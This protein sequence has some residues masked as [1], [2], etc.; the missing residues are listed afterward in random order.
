MIAG[1]GLS[2]VEDVVWGPAAPP[3]GLSGAPRS[4][5]RGPGPRAPTADTVGSHEARRT[6]PATPLVVDAKIDRP[7]ARA[8]VLD[9]PDLWNALDRAADDTLTVLVAPAGYGK[10]TTLATWAARRG[11]VA[12][13]TLDSPDGAP[14]RLLAHVLRTLQRTGH[15][16]GDAWPALVAGA[17]PA[18]VVV[19]LLSNALGAASRPPVLVVDDCHVI[20]GTPSA[21]VVRSL[22]DA[23]PNRLRLVL[24][25]RRAL[26]WPLARRRANGD[27][28][29]LGPDELRLTT[30]EIRALVD[31]RLAVGLSETETTGLADATE[32]WP[33][34]V[35]LTLLR[36]AAGSR[37]LVRDGGTPFDIAEYLVQEV[38]DE[39]DDVMRTFLRRTSI[40]SV[41]DADLCRA[42][43][44]DPAAGELLARARRSNLLLARTDA[45]GTTARYHRLLADVLRAE[46]R[47]SEPE[48][49]GDL[50]RRAGAW[51]AEARRYEDAIEHAIHAGDATW[52]VE[53]LSEI[54]LDLVFDRRY[55]TITSI[56]DRLPGPVAEHD[57]FVAALRM[58]VVALRD[59]LGAAE[60]RAIRDLAAREATP[61]ARRVLRRLRSSFVCGDVRTALDCVD[62]RWDATEPDPRM[63]FAAATQRAMLWW[64]TD[65]P[66]LEAALK[67]VPPAGTDQTL[68]VWHHAMLAFAAA[69]TADQARAVEHGRAAVAEAECDV[70]GTSISFA[71]AYQACGAA[72]LRYGALDHAERMLDRASAATGQV[73]DG[74]EHL[75][76]LMLR[77]RL[78]LARGHRDSARQLAAAAR[79]IADDCV[80]LG[81]L[82]RHLDDTEE[83][84]DRPSSNATLGSPLSPAELRV[85]RM[86]PGGLPLSRIASELFLSTNTVRTHA[87]MIYRRLGANSRADAI[88]AARTRGLLPGIAD[89]PL[90]RETGDG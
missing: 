8:E 65:D 81:G 84:I 13:V 63:R 88:A 62:E 56:L 3:H 16:T 1:N 31:E 25:S 86:L 80:D 60:R 48:A 52:A 27:V 20:E 55:D 45:D 44:D 51:L 69:G 5:R 71:L 79:A 14:A 77:A 57:T 6:A 26:P 74:V 43:L 38:L 58:A 18:S 75:L 23:A 29:E 39:L 17:D 73:P 61:E 59:G 53:L 41:L 82:T 15:E 67:T 40:L 68:R 22:A 70:T 72:Y 11:D 78:E 47:R 32:G 49:V 24:A 54:W 9:R 21:A 4:R 50:H 37:A 66:R 85:L 76:T 90:L 7:V 28:T 19:P 87:R 33:A 34:A 10:T 64:L 89:D 46:L 12:W 35:A 42:V 30:G 36:G 83:A 2:V